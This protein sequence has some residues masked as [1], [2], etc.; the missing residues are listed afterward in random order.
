M[1]SR[2]FSP[3]ALMTDPAIASSSEECLLS[4][5]ATEA[6]RPRERTGRL[7][8]APRRRRR[9]SE[10]RRTATTTGNAR[11]RNGGAKTHCNAVC[12]AGA[13]FKPASLAAGKALRVQLGQ[14]HLPDD[15]GTAPCSAAGFSA[16][17]SEEGSQPR[18]C[19]SEARW[20]PGEELECGTSGQL[21]SRTSRRETGGSTR[22]ARLSQS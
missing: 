8:P 7:I 21:G 18:E 10:G 14:L 11:Y 12:G 19:P 22:A 20:P 9:I 13:P 2:E 15:S 16:G 17:R 5:E 4:M 6:R 3:P 1:W